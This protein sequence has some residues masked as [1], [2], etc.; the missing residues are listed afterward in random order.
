[1]LNYRVER[2]ITKREQVQGNNMNITRHDKRRTKRRKLQVL[3]V[4]VK[5]KLEEGKSSLQYY[6]NTS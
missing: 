3:Y 4:K 2:P 1:M 5:A 6:V